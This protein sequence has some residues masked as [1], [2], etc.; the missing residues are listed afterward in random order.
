MTVHALWAAPFL[1]LGAV[2]ALGWSMLAGHDQPWAILRARWAWRCR[3]NPPVPDE[4]GD[5]RSGT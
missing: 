2:T 5:V 4:G 1:A 3:G